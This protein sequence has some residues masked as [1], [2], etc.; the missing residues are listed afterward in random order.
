MVMF[1]GRCRTHR[2]AVLMRRGDWGGRFHTRARPTIV[3]GTDRFVP[4]SPCRPNGEMPSRKRDVAAGFSSYQ[5]AML[6]D[7]G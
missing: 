2:T 3:T 1:T 7:A 5:L 6:D 4:W